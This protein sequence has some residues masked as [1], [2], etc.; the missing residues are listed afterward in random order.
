MNHSMRLAIFNE[1]VK[2]KLLSI[3]EI[4]FA[5]VI[6]MLK[7]FKTIKLGLHTWCSVRNGPY[8]RMMMWERRICQ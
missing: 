1:H 8:I 5:S 3:A 6:I 4:R 2:M 7:S